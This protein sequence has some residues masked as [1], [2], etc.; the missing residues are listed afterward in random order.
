MIHCPRPKGNGLN[1]ILM[2]A[3][4]KQIALTLKFVHE[5]LCTSEQY[6]SIWSTRFCK[7]LASNAWAMPP[8]GCRCSASARPQAARTKTGAGPSASWNGAKE[9][10]SLRKLMN[11]RMWQGVK[12]KVQEGPFW[13]FV[14]K[15][16]SASKILG[17][18][19]ILEKLEHSMPTQGTRSSRAWYVIRFK[20]CENARKSSWFKNCSLVWQY[21]GG[22]GATEAAPA[23]GKY[24]FVTLLKWT[25]LNPKAQSKALPCVAKDLCRNVKT[26]YTQK[27]PGVQMGREG[28]AGDRFGVSLA[29]PCRMHMFWVGNWLKLKPPWFRALQC[30]PCNKNSKI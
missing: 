5:H 28:T 2:H 6:T 3:E 26:K 15:W 4:F 13:T 20:R 24:P 19:Q 8:R 25:W 16:S 29:Q 21:H 11:S 12:S 14:P 10:F 1:Q 9:C 7:T 23:Q 27:L 22:L 17:K 18:P 30:T